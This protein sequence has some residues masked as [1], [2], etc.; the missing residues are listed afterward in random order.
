M[1]DHRIVRICYA[2]VYFAAAVFNTALAL[3]SPEL[4]RGLAGTAYL[5]FL[6]HL[7]GGAPVAL[8]AA[9]LAGFALY[10]VVLGVLLLSRHYRLGL[11]GGLAFHLA[12][13]PFGPF[14]LLN[15]P[16]ALPLALALRSERV[17]R[18]EAD[19]MN[20]KSRGSVTVAVVVGLLVA[21]LAVLGLS[22]SKEQKEVRSMAIEAVDLT[23]V[24]DGTYRGDF[25]YGKR[26]HLG[27]EVTVATH[28]ITGLKVVQTPGTSHAK[29]P[30]ASSRGCSKLSRR[31]W[32]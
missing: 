20:W 6:R 31:R 16:I 2:V 24:A 26:S 30:R 27:V 32:M 17:A 9:G 10:Q 7:M 14:N 29:R 8:F 22:G 15:V 25:K 23:K 11:W 21:S 13:I 3:R 19:P 1:K 5:P 18:E 28:R 4:L 12:I